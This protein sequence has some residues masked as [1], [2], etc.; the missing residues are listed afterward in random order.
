MGVVG[1]LEPAL[2]H[3]E[4]Q[5]EYVEAVLSHVAEQ[6]ESVVNSTQDS[7]SLYEN[8]DY[9]DVHILT[10]TV[11]TADGDP[12]LAKII[13]ENGMYSAIKC[14]FRFVADTVTSYHSNSS[15][16]MPRKPRKIVACEKH[17]FKPYDSDDSTRID[18][19]IYSKTLQMSDK[20]DKLDYSDMLLI[21]EAKKS[22]C[23]GNND[24]VR[25]ESLKQLCRYTRQI[26]GK[27]PWRRFAWG[28][29]V[30]GS[31]VH[32]YIFGHDC[33]FES[34]I[35]DLCVKDDRSKLVK[36][37]ASW[38]FCPRSILGYDSTIGYRSAA[39][40]VSFAVDG[41]DE[42]IYAPF[43]TRIT[44]NLFGRHTVCY[45]AKAMPLS[46]NEDT[47][48]GIRSLPLDRFVKDA[49]T[50][51]ERDSADDVN[52]E[53][54]FLKTI[55]QKF[56]GDKDMEGKYPL[57][58]AGYVVRYVN[59]NNWDPTTEATAD[60]TLTAFKIIDS[61]IL[62]KTQYRQHK[63]IVFNG[64]AE[65]LYNVMSVD[66]MIVVLADAMY[67]HTRIFRE[68]NILQRDI[69]P[70]NIMFTRG[71]NTIKGMLIDFDCAVDANSQENS[72]PVQTG[73]GPFMSI[74]NLRSSPVRRTQLDDW[75]SLLYL[76]CWMATF[77]VTTEHRKTFRD[78]RDKLQKYGKTTIHI[79]SWDLPFNQ[80]A[81][82][83]KDHMLE[84]MFKPC[85]TDYFMKH[86][87][88]ENLVNLATELRMNIFD[89]PKMSLLGCGVS[90][91]MRLIKNFQIVNSSVGTETYDKNIGPEISDPFERRA[92]CVDEIVND[93]LEIMLTAKVN[94]LQRMSNA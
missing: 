54:R 6:F 42:R 14:I 85:V 76:I 11:I 93:L 30:C 83:K 56:A 44:E 49:W 3:D 5:K 41:I 29:I 9:S 12:I 19:G 53:I 24:G 78:G 62:A 21:V 23:S 87:G 92:N 72:G 68:C 63:R 13:S 36:L 26:Y 84:D 4:R 86:P 90:T 51:S 31:K 38:A 91:N 15:D 89:N 8:D 59:T 81:T 7:G 77:G 27:Q 32:I 18:I 82:F 1:V 33:I 74:N 39:Q 16:A 35:L 22:D 40:C 64:I 47:E 60:D 34:P 65:R 17:D 37:L 94:A 28:M 79:S 66:E 61:E 50:C 20:N 70:N 58:C 10:G 57:L 55:N 25:V 67:A 73:T 52:D 69:S 80:A 43:T 88:Y 75:E 46:C 71:E 48:R 2:P 45:H